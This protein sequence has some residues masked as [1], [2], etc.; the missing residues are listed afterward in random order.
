MTPLEL[1]H[2]TPGFTTLL[3]IDLHASIQ[4]QK[5]GAAKPHGLDLYL[6]EEAQAAQ[7]SQEWVGVSPRLSEVMKMV[8]CVAGTDST[9]LVTGETGT[10]K[11]VITRLIHASSRR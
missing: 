4:R 9:V 11:E 7:N 1:I 5:S 10:G 6:Q 2:I 3:G 8:K